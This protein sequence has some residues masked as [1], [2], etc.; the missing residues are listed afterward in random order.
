MKRN[1]NET[2]EK[3]NK[4]TKIYQFIQ[5]NTIYIHMPTPPTSSLPKPPT[6][7]TTTNKDTQTHTHTHIETPKDHFV[8]K[9]VDKKREFRKKSTQTHKYAYKIIA[10]WIYILRKCH[11]EIP[12]M[13]K[14]YVALDETMSKC[15]KQYDQ[16]SMC[17]LKQVWNETEEEEEEE[18]ISKMM[19]K[20]YVL[21]VINNPKFWCIFSQQVS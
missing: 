4:Y 16:S 2:Y 3:K 7:S 15:E 20:Y 9:C 18:K 19:K 5:Y 11:C 10:K 17:A 1:T 6:T 12:N 13:Y 14:I 8:Y 21:S